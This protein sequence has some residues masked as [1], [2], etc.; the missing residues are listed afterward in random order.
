L[1]SSTPRVTR[2]CWRNWKLGARSRTWNR[3]DPGSV[4][5]KNRTPCVV[6][7]AAEIGK[8]SSI[9]VQ[10]GH[11]GTEASGE[12]HRTAGRRQPDGPPECWELVNRS[13]GR[14][15]SGAV[16]RREIGRTPGLSSGSRTVSRAHAPTDPLESGFA[17]L[18]SFDPIESSRRSRVRSPGAI[19]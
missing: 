10:R 18:L 19:F 8:I 1:P 11:C 6:E 14:C 16:P 4:S 3:N 5:K 17:M 13:A 7:L 9:G 2:W 15:A 12:Y